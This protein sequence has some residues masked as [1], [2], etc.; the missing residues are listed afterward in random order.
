MEKS[1]KERFSAKVGCVFASTVLAASVVAAPSAAFALDSGVAQSADVVAAAED[2]SAA[3]AESLK[4]LEDNIKTATNNLSSVVVS[5]DGSDVASDKKWVDQAAYSEYASAIEDATAVLSADKPLQDDVDN[6]SA[7]LK[8]ATQLF[9]AAKKDGGKAASTEIQGGASTSDAP[10]A[11]N[12][13]DKAPA[14]ADASAA[15]AAQGDAIAK[16]S[17]TGLMAAAAASATAVAAAAAGLFARR[18]MQR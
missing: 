11:A 16:T 8:V 18:R 3:T 6:A 7:D 17:D 5:Q 14:K 9:D 1:Y 10:V 4:W 12:G 15:K 2:S 13:S